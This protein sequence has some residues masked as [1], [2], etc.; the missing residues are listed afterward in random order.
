MHET[1]IRHRITVMINRVLSKRMIE[2]LKESGIQNLFVAG[3]RS[4]VIRESKRIL[5]IGIKENLVDTPLDLISFLVPPELSD[6]ILHQIVLWGD[7]STFGRGSVYSEEITIPCAH[8]IF[9]ASPP[10]TFP[11]EA[12]VKPLQ[13]LQKICCIVQRGKGTD[14]ARAALYS[15]A[16]VPVIYFGTGTGVRDKMGI[17]RITIP[18]EKEIVVLETT[19]HNAQ[20]VMEMM[21][22]MGQL[23]QPGKGFIF[24]CSLKQGVADLQV[25]HGGRRHA[26][27]MEQI[28]GAIDQLRGDTAWRRLA[29]E[30]SRTAL[31][32]RRYMTGLAEL[33]LFINAGKG[34]E[35]VRSAMEA[36]VTGA[37][38]ST[39]RHICPPDAL[40]ARI[41]HSREII[42]MIIPNAILPQV[43]DSLT[44]AGAFSGNCFGQAQLRDIRKAFTYIPKNR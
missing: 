40:L 37:T 20:S 39:G 17:L 13:P 8:D 32:E 18:A 22:D 4:H 3:A 21:I 11:T 42:N 44:E 35:I 9:H 16:G 1:V 28:I 19:P 34:Q 24:T 26:A 43:I 31:K 33:C 36:G 7:L 12:S 38:I 2:H 10:M 5:G 15:G 27:T 41:G 14:I 23:A 25:R 29:E 30:R 6:Q